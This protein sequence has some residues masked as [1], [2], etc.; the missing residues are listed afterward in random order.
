M[1]KIREKVFCYLQGQEKVVDSFLYITVS[2]DSF[3]PM[4]VHSV[5]GMLV[6]GG[7]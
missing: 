7:R 5:S 1:G 6:K 4:S 3:S 2:R